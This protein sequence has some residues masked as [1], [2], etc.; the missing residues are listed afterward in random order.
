MS[1]SKSRKWEEDADLGQGGCSFRFKDDSHKNNS[2]P[3]PGYV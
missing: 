2:S 3:V 1:Y